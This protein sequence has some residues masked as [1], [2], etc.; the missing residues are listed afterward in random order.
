MTLCLTHDHYTKALGS[1]V[2]TRFPAGVVSSPVSDSPS[3]EASGGGGGLCL[4][5]YNIPLSCKQGR[6]PVL[7]NTVGVATA[8]VDRK[9]GGGGGVRRGGHTHAH[10]PPRFLV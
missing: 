1:Y 7:V 8:S 2:S 5:V 4:K 3:W 6:L 10:P 9:R